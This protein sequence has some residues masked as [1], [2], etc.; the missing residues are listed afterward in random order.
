M[1]LESK[2]I[3]LF[4]RDFD[5]NMFSER[6]KNQTEYDLKPKIRVK[7]EHKILRNLEF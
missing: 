3:P 5:A 6:N 1:R 2:G 4:I 7:F